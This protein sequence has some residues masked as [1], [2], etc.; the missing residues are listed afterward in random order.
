MKVR[1][2]NGKRWAGATTSMVNGR[3]FC[4]LTMWVTNGEDGRGVRTVYAYDGMGRPIMVCYP[5]GTSSSTAYDPMG[6][7]V[8][9]TDRLGRGDH[10]LATTM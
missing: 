9:V 7:P 6:K 2:P 8:R 3:T 5:D 1:Q 10:D 4:A